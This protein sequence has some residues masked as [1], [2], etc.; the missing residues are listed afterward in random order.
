[1]SNFSLC[2][3]ALFL[4]N[5][6]NPFQKPNNQNNRPQ[7]PNPIVINTENVAITKNIIITQN[8]QVIEITPKKK[9]R[10][11]EI[12]A[13]ILEVSKTKLDEIGFDYEF[14]NNDLN[15]TI[16]YL[17]SEGFAD[18]LAKPRISALENEEAVIQIGDKIPYAVP[19]GDSSSRWTVQY[20]DTG[21]KLKIIAEIDLDM[22]IATINAEVSSVSNWQVN[23]AGTFPI[24]STRE[25]RTK[26]KTKNNEPIIIGGL[27]ND[28]FRLN[29]Q[30]IPLL[31]DLPLIGFLFNKERQEKIKTDII[32]IILPKIID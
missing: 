17:L 6:P 2:P 13:H 12:E 14:K 7:T 28:Q 11:I 15:I 20:L 23:N 26:I 3:E 18:L 19:F 27:I 9:P 8:P 4:Y 22:I 30:K 31:G 21:I 1:M 24:I 32:F 25:S 29:K 5:K 16:E 10:L